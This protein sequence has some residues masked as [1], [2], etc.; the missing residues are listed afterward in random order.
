MTNDTKHF[1]KQEE[2]VEYGVCINV[3]DRTFDFIRSEINPDDED[4]VNDVVLNTLPWKK[5]LSYEDVV[6][7]LSDGGYSFVEVNLMDDDS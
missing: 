4:D 2:N 7:K 6:K 1:R 5:D 3:S